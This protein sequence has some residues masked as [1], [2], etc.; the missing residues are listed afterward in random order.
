[1][2]SLFGRCRNLLK[3]EAEHLR[4][5]EMVFDLFRTAGFTLNP[6]KCHFG[7]PEIKLLGF[8]IN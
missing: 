1:M 7:V 5:I 2:S 6:A 4:H 3:D 8:I